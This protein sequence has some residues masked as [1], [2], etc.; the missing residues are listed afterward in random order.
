M[1][2]IGTLASGIAHDFNNILGIILA[3][4]TLLDAL[5]ARPQKYEEGIRNISH[6]VQRGAMLV[7]Q[8]LMFARKDPVSLISLDVN[9]DMR[10]IV[11]M[12]EETFPKTIDIALDL[13]IDLPPIL[14]DQTQFQQTVLNLCVNARDAMPG[15]GTLTLASSRISG[16]ALSERFA[17]KKA[18]TYV[19]L[20]VKDTGSGMDEQTKARMYEPFFTT[21]P[22]GKGTGLGLA[23]VYGIVQSHEGFIDVQSCPNQ[24]TTFTLFFPVPEKNSPAENIS[25]IEQK[26]ELCGGKETILLVE[27]E[28][29]LLEIL[30][31]FVSQYGYRVLQARNGVEGLQVFQEHRDEIDIVLSDIGM[32]KLSGDEMLRRIVEIC[33]GTKVVLAS[34]Y[35]DQDQ[36]E[37]MENLGA[38]AFIQKPYRPEFVLGTIRTV[39]DG[40]ERTANG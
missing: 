4:T 31:D 11:Q 23:V 9:E 37:T 6:A 12:L 16:S 14:F 25:L 5:K 40:T 35:F 21:K 19:A 20:S 36:K 29:G 34:G 18:E 2:G 7:H 10:Q 3:Q 13:E 39:L 15:K 38:K 27:D 8:I 24:G 22:Q 32:P 26:E 17:G 30:A 1:E 33:P 28:V